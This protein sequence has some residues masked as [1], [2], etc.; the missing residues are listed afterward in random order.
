MFIATVIVSIA[1][2]ALATMSGLMKIQQNEQVVAG[3]HGT[4]GV[5]LRYFP[6]LAGLEIVGAIGVIVGLW[7]API[8]IAAAA[9]LTAY[10]AGAIIAHI[11]VGDTEGRTR[12]MLPL[13][14]SI[15]ALVLRIV[16]A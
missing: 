4:I 10:F 3:I 9:G 5:P 8:G 1:I 15:V 6:V 12:P 2:A 16:T 7:Y 14:L 11:R 13:A